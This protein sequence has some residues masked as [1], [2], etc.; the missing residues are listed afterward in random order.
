MR[1][2]QALGRR[3][4]L[5]LEDVFHRLRC[6]LTICTTDEGLSAQ[7]GNITTIAIDAHRMIS[8]IIGPLPISVAPATHGEASGEEPNEK[9]RKR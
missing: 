7:A 6:C 5:G 1:R 9:R 2:E 8:P 3:F 4:A